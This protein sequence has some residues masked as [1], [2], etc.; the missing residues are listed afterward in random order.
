MYCVGNY[1]YR[2]KPITNLLVAI[3]GSLLQVLVNRREIF[4]RK[5]WLPLQHV[6]VDALSCFTEWDGTSGGTRNFQGKTHILRN[7]N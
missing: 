3:L 4:V 2:H 7:T 5:L 1:E 6:A